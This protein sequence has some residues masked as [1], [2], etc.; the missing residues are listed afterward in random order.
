[1]SAADHLVSGLVPLALV[2]GAAL[3][4]GRVRAGARATLALLLGYFGVLVGTE[5]VYYTLAGGPFRRRL[6]RSRLALAG[7]LLLGAGT[8]MLWRSRRR[9]D[10]VVRRYV[11]RALIAVGAAGRD[12][13]RPFPHG[14]RLR[15]DAHTPRGGARGPARRTPR[16]RRLRDERRSP[17]RGLVRAVAE[18]RDRDRFPRPLRS[19]E[20]RT[21]C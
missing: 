1:M 5:A 6:H 16:R 13:D 18:R 19:A 21:R 12:R 17:P 10:T 14:A 11:R 4:Y 3:V 2:A 9:N 15:G 8:V 20:A 7:F